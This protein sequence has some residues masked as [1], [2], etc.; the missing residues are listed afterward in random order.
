MTKQQL[1]RQ[2]F[3]NLF[4]VPGQAVPLYQDK[5]EVDMLRDPKKPLPAIFPEGM[6]MA[7]NQPMARASSSVAFSLNRFKNISK[8]EA[9]MT[10]FAWISGLIR[11]LKRPEKGFLAPS[12]VLR[13]KPSN[14]QLS[15]ERPIPLL[16]QIF[17][18]EY[19]RGYPDVRSINP[20]RH[21]AVSP[22]TPQCRI[23]NNSV[24]WY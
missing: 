6:P 13:T 4:E 1:R 17:L 9:T 5:P 2:R 3:Q 18:A 14:H 22:V 16:Q 12:R 11:T 21:T 23:H 15:R 8:R 19:P 20:G 7:R 10:A 24:L